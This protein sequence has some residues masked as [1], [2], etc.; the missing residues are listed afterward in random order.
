[1]IGDR[2]HRLARRIGDDLAYRVPGPSIG[3]KS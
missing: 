3:S 2:C 1:V